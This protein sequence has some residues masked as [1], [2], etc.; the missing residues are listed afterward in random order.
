M[1]Y[2]INWSKIK[3]MSRFFCAEF[4]P[5]TIWIRQFGLLIICLKKI[6]ILSYIVGDPFSYRNWWTQVNALECFFSPHLNSLLSLIGWHECVCPSDMGIWHSQNISIKA[7]C[8][9]SSILHC[10][11]RLQGPTFINLLQFTWSHILGSTAVPMSYW[12]AM[13]FVH[14]LSTLHEASV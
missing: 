13:H 6:S 3:L 8:M 4:K 7:S 14:S 1:V 5:S 12:C 2:F 9:S 11:Y 10:L